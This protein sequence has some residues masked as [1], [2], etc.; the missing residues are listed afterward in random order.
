MAVNMETRPCVADAWGARY[1]KYHKAETGAWVE[2][3]LSSFRSIDLGSTV[4]ICGHVFYYGWISILFKDILCP[5]LT[6]TWR[7]IV[8]YAKLLSCNM[9]D[10]SFC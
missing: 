6:K 8:L 10:L 2:L 9:I 4:V 3:L 5:G 7:F 1:I